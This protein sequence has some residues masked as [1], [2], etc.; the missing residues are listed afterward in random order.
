[1]IKK[2]ISR[3][4]TLL[5]IG[6][7]WAAP[8]LNVFKIAGKGV[9][10]QTISNLNDTM[11]A[12]LSE[13]KDYTVIDCRTYD[14]PE[15][16]DAPAA[17]FCFY[18]KLELVNN[19]LK[20]DL[21]LKN[22]ANGTTRLLTNFY[23]SV[24]MILLESRNLLEKLLDQNYELINASVEPIAV[25]TSASSGVAGTW[26]GEDDIRSIKLLQNGRGVIIFTSGLS[27]SVDFEEKNGT[28]TVTQKSAVTERQFQNLMRELA[29]EAVKKAQPIKWVLTV[30][31][32]TMSGTRSE[33]TATSNDN[34]TLNIKTESKTVRWT[35][36][37]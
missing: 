21:I 19:K 17:D 20:L 28:L 13:N 14:S 24:N 23:E 22:T 31:G 10:E 26:S 32:N 33:T 6:S 12:F 36:V 16:E 1:M 34:K 27:V 35:K 18:G 37:E 11:Y 4:L 7:L 2:T 3:I 8:T 15:A 5:C 9:E 29:A 25:K 30:D